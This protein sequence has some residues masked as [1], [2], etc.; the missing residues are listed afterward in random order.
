[1]NLTESRSC[2]AHLASLLRDEQHAL[3]DFLLALA[4]FD[5]RRGWIELGYSGLFPFLN[6]ELGL[7]K[8]AA[9]FRKT[10][11]R[12]A[13]ALPRD[14]RAP[15]RRPTLSDHHR[16]ARQGPHRGEP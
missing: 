2:A 7:S 11:R 10:D 12:A 3:A 6:R 14:H 5:R 8:A 1:M 15:S 4:D 16:L 13:P 9:F